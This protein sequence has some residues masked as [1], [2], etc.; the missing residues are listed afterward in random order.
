MSVLN[1][2][3][4][5]KGLISK[6]LQANALLKK[7]M[8][9][10]SE[11]TLTPGQV[12]TI[13]RSQ[14]ELNR[15]NMAWNSMTSMS[16]VVGQHKIER[17]E[18]TVAKQ[19][20]AIRAVRRSAAVQKQLVQRLAH[21]LYT[22]GMRHKRLQE[23]SKASIRLLRAVQGQLDGA[24]G[25]TT[26]SGFLG[27]LLSSAAKYGLLAVICDALLKLTQVASVIELLVSLAGEGRQTA[28]RAGVAARVAAVGALVLLLRKK[29]NQILALLRSLLIRLA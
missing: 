15:V 7:S 9:S 25:P 20:T 12:C 23:T 3:G 18:A 28:V 24:P 11:A 22:L 19:S 29:Y 21:A 14:A 8:D 1:Q 10:L 16:L 5:I 17:L 6:G 13:F 26:V 27:G 2:Q 4:A